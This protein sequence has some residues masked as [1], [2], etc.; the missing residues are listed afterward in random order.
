MYLRVCFIRD[1]VGIRAFSQTRVEEFEWFL[2]VSSI[3]LALA[4]LS[5]IIMRENWTQ[6]TENVKYNYCVTRACEPKSLRLDECNDQ[7]TLICDWRS[8]QNIFS[9]FSIYH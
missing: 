1:E 3:T 9:K 7:V 4:V 5:Y 2:N 8:S 6:V